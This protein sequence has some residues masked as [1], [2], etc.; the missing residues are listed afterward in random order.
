MTSRISNLQKEQS[1]RRSGCSGHRSEMQKGFGF[2]RTAIAGQENQFPAFGIL[3]GLIMVCLSLFDLVK[4][5][6]CPIA[7]VKVR[8]E[9]T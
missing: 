5:H 7:F 4:R 1:G 6:S 2:N 3:A 8:S 9:V